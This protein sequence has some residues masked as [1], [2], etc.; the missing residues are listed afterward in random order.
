GSATTI[1]QAALADLRAGL[2]GPVLL[3][4][5]PGYDQSRRVLNESINRF[6]ALVVQPTGVA[7][8]QR[9]VGFARDHELLLAVKCGGHSPGGKSTC[10]RGM[11]IDLSRF[12]GVRVD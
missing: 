1:E 8:I 5:D 6:P 4:G 3:A 12:R 10:D 9:A 11:Q 7:D 2:R